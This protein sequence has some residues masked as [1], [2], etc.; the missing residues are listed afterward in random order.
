MAAVCYAT[1]PPPPLMGG[2]S[3]SLPSSARARGLSR[4]PYSL[5]SHGDEY[6]SIYLSPAALAC[7]I[8]R[9]LSLMSGRSSFQRSSARARWLSP[10][11][12][13]PASYGDEYVAI[14]FSSMAAACWT[15][16]SLP[17]FCLR[18]VHSGRNL[19]ALRHVSPLK[20][21]SRQRRRRG[22][23]QQLLLKRLAEA[24]TSRVKVENSR[25]LEVVLYQRHGAPGR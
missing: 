2:R 6:V 7:W 20:A 13:F 10:S 9:S 24:K 22:H 12:C 4:S 23:Q 18:S 19:P 25:Q 1:L 11:T 16:P 15:S 5:P 17:A 8:S 3:A 14:Y 21:S